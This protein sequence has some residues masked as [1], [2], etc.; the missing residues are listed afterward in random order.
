MFKLIKFYVLKENLQNTITQSSDKN[1]E[2]HVTLR[3]LYLIEIYE[4]QVNGQSACSSYLPL[5]NTTTPKM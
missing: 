3:I 4:I 1:I 2:S 5:H